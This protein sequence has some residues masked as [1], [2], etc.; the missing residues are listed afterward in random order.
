MEGKKGEKP[1]EKNS[2]S[3]ANPEDQH[4]KEKAIAQPKGEKGK[5]KEWIT[6]SLVD[7]IKGVNNLS[8]DIADVNAQ[9]NV[10]LSDVNNQLMLMKSQT[11]SIIKRLAQVESVVGKINNNLTM[12]KE[13]I[14]ELKT[15]S[16]ET[17][18][19]RRPPLNW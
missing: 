4:T 6:D 2:I 12:A 3:M 11:D 10:G 8:R 13:E 14:G 5:G 19:P 18:A 1:K 15:V 7:L 17:P 9:V 16:N